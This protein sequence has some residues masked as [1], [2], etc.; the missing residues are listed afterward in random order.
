MGVRS[1]KVPKGCIGRPQTSRPIAREPKPREVGAESSL[2]PCSM[3][4]RMKALLVLEDFP[5]LTSRNAAKQSD[6]AR[7]LR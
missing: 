2:S 4:K 6:E 1:K 7:C 5:T 3:R